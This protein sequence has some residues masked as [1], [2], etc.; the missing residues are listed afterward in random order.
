[1]EPFACYG[2]PTGDRQRIYS[3]GLGFLCVVGLIAW[4]L[5]AD[6]TSVQ[7]ARSDDNVNAWIFSEEFM[8]RKLDSPSTASF[9]AYDKSKVSSKPS[10]GTDNY[11]VAGCVDVENASGATLRKDFICKLHKHG[12]LWHLDEITMIGG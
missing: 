6:T 7:P 11:T 5:A 8:K 4:F 2:A 9:C 1:V 12:N 10:A 3:F